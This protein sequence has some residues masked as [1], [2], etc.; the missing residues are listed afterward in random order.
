MESAEYG[1]VPP[2][3]MV[4]WLYEYGNYR[5]FTNTVLLGCPPTSTVRQSS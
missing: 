3:P 1:E 2:L 5:R 4:S